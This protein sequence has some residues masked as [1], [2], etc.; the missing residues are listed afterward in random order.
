MNKRVF[1]KYSLAALVPAS[2]ADRLLANTST[3]QPNVDKILAVQQ[4]NLS[5]LNKNAHIYEEGIWT[6]Q[7]RTSRSISLPVLDYSDASYTR[8]GNTVFGRIGLFKGVSLESVGQ[9]ACLII[10][11]TG[12]PGVTNATEFSGQAYIWSR[13]EP[14]NAI[15]VKNSYASTDIYIGWKPSGS[16]GPITFSGIAFSYRV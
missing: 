8:I 15:I 2:I 10:S 1:F 13:G 9:E 14:G 11:S 7:L 3:A 6:P 5:K 16:P 4:A 12:L